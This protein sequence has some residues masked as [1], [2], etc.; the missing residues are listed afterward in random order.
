VEDITNVSLIPTIWA[1][2]GMRY[3]DVMNI[4]K[5][6]KDGRFTILEAIYQLGRCPEKK[7]AFSV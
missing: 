5:K 3:E 6:D 7:V 2:K 1:R 4:I